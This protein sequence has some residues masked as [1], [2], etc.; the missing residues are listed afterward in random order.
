MVGREEL[1]KHVQEGRAREDAILLRLAA[2]TAA[3][4][5]RS[6]A[7]EACTAACPKMS[8]AIT[9]HPTVDLPPPA[10]RSGTVKTCTAACQS[11]AVTTDPTVDLPPPADGLRYSRSNDNLRKLQGLKDAADGV[12]GVK[13]RAGARRVGKSRGSVPLRKRLVPDETQPTKESMCHQNDDG[14]EIIAVGKSDC[15]VVVFP[16]MLASA[17]V[18]IIQPP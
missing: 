13:A 12:E 5:Q 8:P 2:I 1:G 14:S 11:S 6:E 3:L 7:V 10:E 9:T 15:D 4:D 17:Q 18:Y 16:R